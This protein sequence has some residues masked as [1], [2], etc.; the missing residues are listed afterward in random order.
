[1]V[2]AHPV[3]WRVSATGVACSVWV[4]RSISP[5]GTPSAL[6]ERCTNASNTACHHETEDGTYYQHLLC[7][8][9]RTAHC[10]RYWPDKE[11]GGNPEGARAERSE[12]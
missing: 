6:L 2:S 7:E 11:D 10:E 4:P 8:E 12:P 3:R 9:H 5:L 1:M